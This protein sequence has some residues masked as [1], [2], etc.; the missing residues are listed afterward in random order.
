MKALLQ[1]VFLLGM[2]F[3]DIDIFECIVAPFFGAFGIWFT[4]IFIFSL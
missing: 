3:E 4:L 2:E 1:E